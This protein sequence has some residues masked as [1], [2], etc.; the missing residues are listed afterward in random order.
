MP[1]DR[2]TANRS[3][4]PL[5]GTVGATAMIGAMS[6]GGYVHSLLPP[7]SAEVRAVVTGLSTAVACLLLLAVLSRLPRTRP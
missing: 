2:S 5:P 4:R 6:V 3:K 1:S 7:G